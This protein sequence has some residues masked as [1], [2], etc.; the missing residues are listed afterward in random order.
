MIQL[1]RR[2]TTVA[3][4]RHLLALL[5]YLILV[6]VFFARLFYPQAKV[7]YTPD[8]GRSDIWHQ[9]YPFKEALSRSLAQGT[10]PF[11]SKDLGTGFPIFAEGQVGSLYL[12]N[13]LLF[14][15]LPT[16]LAWNLSFPLLVLLAAFGAYLFFVRAGISR[17]SSMIAAAAFGF[18]GYF[19]TKM[20][21]LNF[22]QAAALLP[23]LFLLG[24]AYWER[25]TWKRALAFAF[26]LEQQVFTGGFQWV[27]ISLAGLFLYS[28]AQFRE[29]DLDALVYRIASFAAVTLFGLALS[30]PQ[31]LP[32]LEFREN[33][34]RS[35]GLTTAQIFQ[36]PYPVK[37]LVTFILPNA[38]GTP[39]DGTY[40]SPFGKENIGIFWENTAYVGLAPLVFMLVS[41]IVRRKTR[42]EKALLVLGVSALLLSLGKGSP[43]SFLFTYSGFN[44]F[45]V[46]SRFLILVVLSITA[47]AGFGLDK[48]MKVL[49]R[50]R[51]LR[52]SLAGLMVLAFLVVILDLFHFG[53]NYHPSVALSEALEPPPILS[54]LQGGGRI[55]T[56]PDQGGVWN[57][58]FLKRGWKDVAPYLY[59]KNGMDANLNLVFGKASMWVGTAFR[60]LRTEL[61]GVFLPSLLNASEVRWVISPTQLEESEG[62]ELVKVVEP[63]TEALPT[64]LVYSNTKVLARFRVVSDY[65]VGIQALDAKEGNTEPFSFEQT[66]ILEDDPGREFERV[67]S[68]DLTVVNDTDRLIRLRTRTDAEALLLIADSFYPGWEARIDRKPTDILAANV[69]QRA[70]ILPAGEHLVEM[71][72]AP[73]S[74]IRGVRMFAASLLAFAFLVLVTPRLAIGKP[75]LKTLKRMILQP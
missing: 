72:Y 40:P 67:N 75:I 28:V 62:F 63:T 12:P 45:R 41:L 10:L 47:L 57:E 3:K 4:Q 35:E 11:W 66:A 20:V 21:H 17:G 37:H 60:P 7:F 27:F 68:A 23:W 56:H 2:M 73:R 51:R 13:L 55:Y 58:V 9:N 52:R 24:D 65:V 36:F 69:N 33:S 25:H 22:I 18:S 59:F 6:S 50:R 8:Y 14:R 74:F 70:L 61:M 42:K 31:I 34:S 16:W 19:V 5:V 38:F 15:F 46:P 26:I 44:N 53:I 54:A 49:Y 39:K 64:Y 1:M 71:E 30:A 43:L 48:L 32:T 29:R